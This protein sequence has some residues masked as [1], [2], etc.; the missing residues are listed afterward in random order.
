MRKNNPTYLTCKEIREILLSGK[1]MP[2]AIFSA[3]KTD[4]IVK[5]RT[6]FFKPKRKISNIF[7]KILFKF[8][9]YKNI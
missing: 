1:D 4:Y 9:L 6:I 7:N 5:P 8:T 3:K 2:T